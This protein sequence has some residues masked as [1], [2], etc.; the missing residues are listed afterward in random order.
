MAG[1][2]AVRLQEGLPEG[3]QTLGQWGLGSKETPFVAEEE[4]DWRKAR[5]LQL[6]VRWNRGC[7]SAPLDDPSVSVQPWP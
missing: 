5:M 3:L 4:G 7:V 2:S 1:D 6:V